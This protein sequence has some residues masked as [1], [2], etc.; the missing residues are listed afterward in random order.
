MAM[1]L[2]AMYGTTS[3][4]LKD[5]LVDPTVNLKRD[6]EIEGIRWC[7][8]IENKPPV[9]LSHECL[10]TE[11]RGDALHLPRQFPEEVGGDEHKSDS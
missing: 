2:M 5:I 4:Q 1:N 9:L 7:D 6:E 8:Q 11:Q 10:T 3:K